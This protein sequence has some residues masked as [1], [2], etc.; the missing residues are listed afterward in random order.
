MRCWDDC[1]NYELGTEMGSTSQFLKFYKMTE[2]GAKIDGVT[3]EEV[4]EVLIHRLKGLNKKAPCAENNH[5]IMNLEGAL[6]WLRLRTQDRI[7]RGVEGT[8]VR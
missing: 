3:N 6:V 7:E 2:D 4:L 5:A 8:H 1:H